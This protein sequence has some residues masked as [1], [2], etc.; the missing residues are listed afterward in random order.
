MTNL[1]PGTEDHRATMKWGVNTAGGRWEVMHTRKSG[2]TPTEA[3]IRLSASGRAQLIENPPQKK[4]RKGF[5]AV[6]VSYLDG[7][8]K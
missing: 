4:E 7:N 3:L 6:G 5:V 1:G 2:N 8:G